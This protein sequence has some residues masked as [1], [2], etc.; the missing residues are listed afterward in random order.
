VISLAPCAVA[1]H[2]TPRHALCHRSCH[3]AQLPTVN[4]NTTNVVRKWVKTTQ[5]TRGSPTRLHLLLPL[6][7]R[8]TKETQGTLF[9]LHER[10]QSRRWPR[11]VERAP[12][13]IGHTHAIPNQMPLPT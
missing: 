5:K 7:P 4:K 6:I 12:L 1:R 2:A 3:N 8:N 9:K 13:L 11:L 10:Q